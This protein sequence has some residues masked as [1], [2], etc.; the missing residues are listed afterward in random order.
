M[1]IIKWLVFNATKFG[2]VCY[3]AIISGPRVQVTQNGCH[4][5]MAGLLTNTDSVDT[6]SIPA[7]NP[8]KL[9]FP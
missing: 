4:G 2:A 3:T 8:A 9:G 7:F 1:C 5:P 6:D